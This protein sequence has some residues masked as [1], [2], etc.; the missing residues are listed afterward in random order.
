MRRYG[1][2]VCS[3]HK[4]LLD[5]RT[6]LKYSLIRSVEKVNS[7]IGK[8]SFSYVLGVVKFIYSVN[9]AP[10]LFDIINGYGTVQRR[11]LILVAAYHVLC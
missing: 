11:P 4:I 5:W 10:F 9:G 7:V 1:V 6:P 8:S 2:A 3:I